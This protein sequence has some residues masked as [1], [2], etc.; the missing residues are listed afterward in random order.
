MVPIQIFVNIL[1]IFLLSFILF[2]LHKKYRSNKFLIR[3]TYGLI[4]G[5]FTYLS[6]LF[7][8]S[9]P[10]GTPI[11]FSPVSVS[12]A[13]LLFGG[14]TGL[15]SAL[16]ILGLLLLH[17]TANLFLT[18]SIVLFA[19][20]AGLSGKYYK[21]KKEHK[22]NTLFHF[23]I[24]GIFV[25]IA[26]FTITLL[27]HFKPEIIVLLD[28][29]IY[30]LGTSPLIFLLIGYFYLED[31]ERE[32]VIKKLFRS[33]ERY[34]LI[35]DNISEVISLFDLKLNYVFTTPSIEKLLGYSYK[36]LLGKNVSVLLTSESLLVAK[37][38]L[39]SE[40]KLQLS[41]NGNPHVK[42]KIISEEVKK[43]GSHIFVDNS[44]SLVF[45][46]KGK[47]K[48]V[49]VISR[50]I[51]EQLKSEALLKLSEE[52]F[53]TIFETIPDP[54][55]ITK[56]DDGTYLEV[57]KAFEE[58]SGYKRE[59]VLGKTAFDI[60]VWENENDRK[61]LVKSL[62]ETGKVNGLEV[63]FRLRDNTIVDALISGTFL[64]I[65]GRKHLLLITKVI[66][67]LK[68]AIKAAKSS[69]ANLSALINN[70]DESIWSIDT[71]YNYIVFNKKFKNDFWEA[72]NIKLEKGLNAIEILNIEEKI[73]W[74]SKYD[75]ALTGKKIG[76]IYTKNVGGKVYHMN[77]FLSPIFEDEKI[78]GV[79]AIAM[80]ITEKR[81]A[82]IELE[83][84]E[85]RYRTIFEGS[86]AILLLIDAE[87]AD[88]ID[89][90][91][92]AVEFYGWK[93]EKLL[94]MK[95]S[96]INILPSDEIKRRMKIAAE[97][98]KN[99]F[100]FTHRTAGN[101]MKEVE[102]YATPILLNGR[103]VLFALI[104]DVTE[105]RKNE[106]ELEE[107]RKLLELSQKIAGMGSWKLD[108]LNDELYWSDEVYEIF[109]Y[110][111]Q[112][113]TATYEAF[114]DAVYPDD[115]KLFDDAYTNSIKN[116]EDSYQVE[117]RIIRKDNGEI[118]NVF[119]RCV[120]NRD[121]EGNIYQSVGIVL[122]ITEQ[123]K[124]EKELEDLLG[125]LTNYEDEM[126]KRVSLELHD[127][128][129]Q[130][131]TALSIYLGQLKFYAL[132][133]NFKKDSLLSTVNISEKMV[134]KITERI[135]DIMTELNP[136]M[137]EDF[138]LKAGLKWA[139][140]N[141]MK[142]LPIEV[143]YFGKDLADEPPLEISNLLLKVTQEALHNVRKHSEAQKVKMILEEDDSGITILIEDDGK[144]FDKEEVNRL[145]RERHFGLA[146]MEE[147]IKY[148]G[149][150][151]DVISQP[152]Q[153][154][155][156]IIRLSKDKY[157]R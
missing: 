147:R 80:D 130:D 13:T 17:N 2:K 76:F 89:A 129:G 66:T 90:N 136:R 62:Q 40:I 148:I 36:E 119:E 91:D 4:V 60:N 103:K 44:A 27:F 83:E 35:T 131:L 14:V 139:I 51:T 1:L 149:G 49:L 54:V 82:E 53:K 73:F 146:S 41:G 19:F 126:R 25:G 115:R 5:V 124:K 92:S 125:R 96:E 105:K 142:G 107:N 134:E 109:G 114:L 6:V 104:N 86:K 151:L 21:D 34:K 141:I 10:G 65:N 132:N 108:I 52:K 24:F 33:E 29:F 30:Y 112:E 117:H 98:K 74:K 88:I 37:E 143:S 155:T 67:E 110:D 144:G 154:T 101:E 137:L 57:N 12:L 122:D 22:K 157:V 43:D 153:G 121:E 156:V 3:G 61:E 15:F 70:G 78:K 39:E 77:V 85:N 9:V 59:E 152:G 93:G 58:I 106:T 102:V 111:P 127:S 150:D 68:E 55:T 99:Y 11:D 79:S 42:K 133:E 50:D 18:L 138:G 87:T 20:I 118:R 46:G 28:M 69:E 135:R 95:I 47:P 123:K 71:R 45:D 100:L 48:Y 94:S 38:T 140:E 113:F 75:I 23:Y 64:E 128:V 81:N 7:P 56:A 16:T 120:H 84:S 31:D 8:I 72:H 97:Q 63:K 145:K 26:T 32:K 116:N